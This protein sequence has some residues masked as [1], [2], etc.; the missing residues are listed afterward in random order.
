MLALLLAV[1]CAKVHG[2][3]PKPQEHTSTTT[4]TVPR[5]VPSDRFKI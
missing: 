1:A 5:P 4:R 2:D 3:D